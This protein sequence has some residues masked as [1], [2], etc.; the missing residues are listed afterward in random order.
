MPSNY[1]QENANASACIGEALGQMGASDNNHESASP[2]LGI[3]ESLRLYH[4]RPLE[5][6]YVGPSNAMDIQKDIRVHG[7]GGRLELCW[8]IKCKYLGG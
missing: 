8:D 3:V 6:H 1:E 4:K 7:K 5:H 2:N